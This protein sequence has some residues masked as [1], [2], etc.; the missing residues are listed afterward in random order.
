MVKLVVFGATGYA[1][2]HIVDE[3]LRRGLDVVGVARHTDTLAERPGLTVRAGSLH[4]PALVDE[5]AADADVLVVAVPARI[6]ADGSSLLDTIGAVAGTAAKHGARVG[7][8]GGAGSLSTVEGGPRLIDTPE[9]PD[10]YKAEATAHAQVLDALR[11]TPAEVDWFYVS[12]SAEFGSWA[13]G[14]R[15]GRFRVGTDV[16]LIDADGKSH[17]GGDDYATAFVDEIVTP[18]HRRKRFTV[19]Y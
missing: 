19:G 2:G 16:L 6:Q 17:I 1:G 4:D 3:A 12:P 13:A 18:S 9:F 5:L 10:A 7:V 11:A 8:V 15:T 14:E